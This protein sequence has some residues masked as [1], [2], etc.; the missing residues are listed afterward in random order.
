MLGYSFRMVELAEEVNT[1]APVYVAQRI[2]EELNQRAL[3]VNGARVLLLG[4]TYKPDVA[5]LRET[6]AEPL[7][8]RLLQQGAALSF[9]DQHWPWRSC[10]GSS[11]RSA[12]PSGTWTGSPGRSSSS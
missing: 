10:G 12:W 2:S 6:P 5:D 4:V 8:A 7:A 1:A 9:H 3:A 11:A